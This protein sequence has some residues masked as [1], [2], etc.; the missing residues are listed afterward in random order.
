MTLTN[1]AYS[2]PEARSRLDPPRPAWWRSFVPRSLRQF[3]PR[4]LLSPFWWLRTWHPWS[5]LALILLFWL[6]QQ[7][8]RMTHQVRLQ[9]LFFDRV[10]FRDIEL[11]LSDFVRPEL[12]FL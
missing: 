6:L 11:M 12:W 7:D 5:G 1:S 4:S 8:R 2:P 9:R 10:N 3:Q